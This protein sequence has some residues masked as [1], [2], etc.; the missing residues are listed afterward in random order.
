MGPAVSTA[1]TNTHT[2]IQT[3]SAQI[4]YFH[5]ARLSSVCIHELSVQITGYIYLGRLECI[6][7][8]GHTAGLKCVVTGRGGAM[9]MQTGP[10]GSE[11]QR[12]KG[13]R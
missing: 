13:R 9:R 11:S 2:H 7:D 8:I 5:K 10:R 6:F 3:Q 4:L 1:P 12:R